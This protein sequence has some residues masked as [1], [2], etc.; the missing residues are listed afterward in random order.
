MRPMD[1]LS[2]GGGTTRRLPAPSGLRVP[3]GQVPVELPPGP[4]PEPKSVQPYLPLAPAKP[5]G[6]VTGQVASI[7]VTDTSDATP[8]NEPA[9]KWSRLHIFLVAAVVIAVA[10]VA[11]VFL[12]PMV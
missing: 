10:A 2:G 1:E 4:M 11:V 6:P 8:T 3:T 7:L 5:S 12:S 9:G